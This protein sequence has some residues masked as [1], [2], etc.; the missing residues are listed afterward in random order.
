MKLNGIGLVVLGAAIMNGVSADAQTPRVE[1][2]FYPSAHLLAV[3]G[4]TAAQPGFRE[5]APTAAV[6]VNLSAYFAVEGEL[7]GAL[8]VTQNLGAL[9]RWKTPSMLGFNGN[10]VANLAPRHSVQPYLAVG[11]GG[12][13]M[14]T[15]ESLGIGHPENIETANAGGGVKVM[16]GKWGLRADYRF[17]GLDSKDGNPSTFIGSDVRHAHRIFGGFIIAPGRGENPS[18]VLTH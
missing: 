15:R 16:F 14:F 6:A 3:G 7:S 4:P 13:L 8:G 17:V 11:V 5:N 10:I 2:T 18:N 1:V 12:M 9:G